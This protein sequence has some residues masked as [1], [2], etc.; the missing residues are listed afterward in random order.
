MSDASAREASIEF[1]NG[2]SFIDKPTDE[3]PGE[4]LLEAGR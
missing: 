1:E 3:L 4:M 2:P